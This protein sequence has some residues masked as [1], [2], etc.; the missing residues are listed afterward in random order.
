MPLGGIGAC[1][2]VASMGDCVTDRRE[3]QQLLVKQAANER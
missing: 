2:W 1:H 3:P